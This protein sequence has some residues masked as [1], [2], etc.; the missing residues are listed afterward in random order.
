LSPDAVAPAAWEALIEAGLIQQSEDGEWGFRPGIAERLK[1]I[2]DEC[3]LLGIAILWVDDAFAF[4]DAPSAI[5]LLEQQGASI[6]VKN[7]VREAMSSLETDGRYDVL[8]FAD[9]IAGGVRDLMGPVRRN[10]PG[11]PVIV[12]SERFILDAGVFGRTNAPEKLLELVK[13]AA[14][15]PRGEV[16]KSD[17]SIKPLVYISYTHADEPESSADGDARWLTFVLQFLQPAMKRGVFD[18]FWDYRQI[19]P[20]VD[21]SSAIDAKLRACD[22]FFLLVCRLMRWRRTNDEIELIKERQEN[23]E[24]VHFYPLLLKPTPETGLDKVRDKNLRP[25]VRAPY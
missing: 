3:P 16:R 7:G 6:D 24:L 21:W 19:G 8:I 25:R 10:A 13:R 11:I 23:G 22:I 15:R 9:A 1:R 17:V 5:G 2:D 20:G 12:Y 18:A 4:R 14:R